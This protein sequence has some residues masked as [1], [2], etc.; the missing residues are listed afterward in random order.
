MDSTLLDH[1]MSLEEC[2]AVGEDVYSNSGVPTDYLGEL[3]LPPSV[4]GREEER[5]GVRVK[6]GGKKGL[7]SSIE[8]ILEVISETSPSALSSEL[9]ST[10]VSIVYQDTGASYIQCMSLTDAELGGSGCAPT[11]VSNRRDKRGWRKRRRISAR[12]T[13][14]KR[15]PGDARWR[16][17]EVCDT[18]SEANELEKDER[19]DML[20]HVCSDSEQTVR[21][22]LFPGG[23]HATCTVLSA[24][25][26]TVEDGL[27]SPPHSCTDSTVAIPALRRE[28]Y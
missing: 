10:I 20:S 22:S 6:E 21:E 18:E 2:F 23:I 11:S 9:I 25:G 8:E 26:F 7:Q 19:K 27:F 5:A 24:G 28:V 13:T 16:D 1:R 4:M 15:G 14:S 12:R 17:V 3:P